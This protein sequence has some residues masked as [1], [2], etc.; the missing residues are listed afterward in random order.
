MKSGLIGEI[1]ELERGEKSRVWLT[2]RSRVCDNKAR[3]GDTQS[4]KAEQG[5]RWWGESEVGAI[6][7]FLFLI[8]FYSSTLGFFGFGACRGY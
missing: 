5:R 8:L 6:G 3:A 4:R 2:N 1:G 7:L